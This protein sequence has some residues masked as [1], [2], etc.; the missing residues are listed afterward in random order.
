MDENKTQENKQRDIRESRVVSKRGDNRKNT[1]KYLGDVYDETGKNMSKIEAKG[2]KIEGMI[3]NIMQETSIYKIGRNSTKARKLII[4]SIAAPTLLN[5]T[6]TWYSIN[7]KEEEKIRQQHQTIITRCLEVHKTTPYY[8]IIAEMNVTPYIDVI[9]QRKIMWLYNIHSEE[10]SYVKTVRKP[11]NKW[12]E[13]QEY[14][15]ACN[16]NVEEYIKNTSKTKYKEEF[17]KKIREK[18]IKQLTEQKIDKKKLRFIKPGKEQE[19][20]KEGRCSSKETAD[21]MKIRLNMI[22]TRSN[23][24]HK[25]RNTVCRKCGKEEETT[26]HVLECQGGEEFDEDRVEDVE[27]LKKVMKTYKQ[28]DVMNKEMDSIETE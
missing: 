18:V 14:A 22:W 2:E 15:N 20:L 26:E 24:K 11:A 5:N 25:N 7:T 3:K 1:Y 4:T 17:K 23:F 16:I 27:W 9:W 21:I 28:I 12:K 19:Y 6:E 8:G 13:V 10:E